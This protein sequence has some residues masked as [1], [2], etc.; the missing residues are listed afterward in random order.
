MYAILQNI[1]YIGVAGIVF[2]AFII[3]CIV[4]GGN[5][6]DQAGPKNNSNSGSNS[7]TT[8]ENK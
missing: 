6:G 5:S 1:G 8:Q 7:N 2:L 4:K 3:F